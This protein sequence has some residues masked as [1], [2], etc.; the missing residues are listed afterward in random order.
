MTLDRVVSYMIRV[1]A[2][3][4]A[5]FLV[6]MPDGRNELRPYRKSIAQSS[7]P[8]R[9]GLAASALPDD[10]IRVEYKTRPT[11]EWIRRGINNFLLVCFLSCGI[12]HADDVFNHPQTAEQLLKGPLSRPAA[13]LRT[14]QVMRGKFIYKKFLKEIPQ[15]LISHGDFLF[16]RDVGI[17]WHT[18]DPFDSDFV[19]TAKGMTQSDDGKVTLQMNAS[20]QPAVQIVAHIFLSLLSLDVASLQ[21]SFALSGMQQGKPGSETWQVGMRPTVSA[22]AAVFKEAV[23][24]GDTQ[25]QSLVLTDA[26][27]D[28]TEISFAD[29]QYAS[30]ITAA[31]RA[32]LLNRPHSP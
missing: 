7:Y 21:N 4:I 31:E 13:A 5:S 14:A 17:D 26:N 24:S 23:V 15:P 11:T 3:F 6:A 20:E 1:G 18:R 16:A 2:Q 9:S 25:V 27:G 32:Q 29:V 30:S 10:N 12:A 22:I 8:C 28:H 19:L